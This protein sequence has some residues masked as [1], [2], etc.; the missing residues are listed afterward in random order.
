MV[1]RNYKEITVG[2]LK[3][4]GI[5]VKEILKVKRKR[6]NAKKKAQ[7]GRKTGTRKEETFYGKSRVGG[8]GG[9]GVPFYPPQTTVI[10]NTSKDDKQSEEEKKKAEKEKKKAEKERKKLEQANTALTTQVGDVQNQLN[11]GMEV[12]KVVATDYYSNRF[13]SKPNVP[14]QRTY[15]SEPSR[16][17]YDRQYDFEVVDVNDSV[18]GY[19]GGTSSDNFVPEVDEEEDLP[20]E[21]EPAPAVYEDPIQDQTEEKSDTKDEVTSRMSTP[22]ATIKPTPQSGGGINFTIPSFYKS[23]TQSNKKVIPVEAPPP[24]PEP[25]RITRS[26]AEEKKQ[27]QEYAP[28]KKREKPISAKVVF[29]EEE[30]VAA[31]PPKPKR[32]RRTKAQM[33]AARAE[34]AAQQE[35]QRKLLK[36]F[37]DSNKSK[38]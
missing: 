9:G 37:L 31:P 29:E 15:F 6:R 7:G 34:E 32:V 18:G 27:E 22:S 4:L 26:K 17:V 13:Q 12:L 5:D 1:K 24:T 35:V 11:T 3:R 19:A 25:P 28:M 10:T 36:D 23:L 38:K 14:E 16:N 21:E 33:E 30:A 20:V 8:G 2:E